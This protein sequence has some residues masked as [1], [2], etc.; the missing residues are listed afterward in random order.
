MLATRRQKP[1]ET[2]TEFLQDLRK[3]SK[4]CN[5]KNVTAEQYREELIRDS[6]ING[7]L[8][9]SIRQ[10]LLENAHL[11][12]KTAFDQANAL[13]LAQKNAEAYATPGSVTAAAV[14]N[15]SGH[16]TTEIPVPDETPLTAT[17]TSKKCYFCGGSVHNRRNCPARNSQCNNCGKKGHYAKVCMSKAAK[18]SASTT[19]SI[20]AAACPE[21]LMQ[22]SVKVTVHGNVLTALLDSGSS[23]S[24]ISGNVAKYLSLKV[25][26]SSQDISMALPSFKTRIIGYCFADINLNQRTYSSVRLGVLNNLCSD[27][28][29]GQDFQKQHKSVIFEFGGT[30][31]ELIIPTFT[32]VCAFSAA[33]IEEPS[34]FTNP[35][36]G[37]KPIAS[38][39]RRFSK[40]DQKFIQQEI[41]KLLSEGIIEPSVSPWRAQVVVAK[42]PS[43]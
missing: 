15:S 29:L 30:K 40:E 19:A 27:I 17:L 26:P 39:S 38:K 20:F 36:P 32:P 43:H 11:D 2:L 16:Q 18:A 33:S 7:L 41:T 42:D 35:I 23:D 21:S 31:P 12:L 24:F 5:F 37:C 34:L 3:L 13:D 10:R 8:S 4:N 14:A 6:F 25:H 22:A 1:G 28:I 9:P